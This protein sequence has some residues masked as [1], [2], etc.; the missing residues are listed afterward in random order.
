MPPRDQELPEGTDAIINGAMETGAGSGA[1]T[2]SSAAS[3]IGGGFG[4]AGAGGTTPGG[5][6]GTT[7]SGGFIGGSGGGTGGLPSTGGSSAG[8]TGGSG[9]GSSSGSG[10]SGSGA[11]QKMADQVRSQ[12]DNLKGQAT[13]K[14]RQFADTGKEKAT[15][16]LNDFAEV[17]N[18]AARSVDERLGAEY[19]AY[20]H[21]AADAVTSLVDGLRSRSVDDLLED[22][23]DVVRKSPGVAIASAALLGF[24]LMRVVKAGLPEKT[25]NDVQ[26]Q[27]DQAL[28]G[29]DTDRNS[30]AIASG[31]GSQPPS[32]SSTTGV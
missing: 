26:F 16:A 12:V 8:T 22:T 6:S 10:G 32:V 28:T 18:D 9:G 24:A 21:R 15:T 17:V 3:G 2:G 27:P 31:T 23:R 30:G 4:G 14:V 19:G 1:S 13:E 5:G 7:G 25:D 20:A 29:P 11:S